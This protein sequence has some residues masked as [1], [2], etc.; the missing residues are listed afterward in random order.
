M[1]LINLVLMGK[2]KTHTPAYYLVCSFFFLNKTDCVQCVYL[3]LRIYC[4][5]YITSVFNV[6]SQ[7]STQFN[8]F[9][10]SYILQTLSVANNTRM[11]DSSTLIPSIMYL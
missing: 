10:K 5:S 11:I 2:T 1:K 7:Y 4:L 8:I 6:W 3:N 9:K